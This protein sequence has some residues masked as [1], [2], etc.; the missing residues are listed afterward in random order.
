MLFMVSVLVF[1]SLTNTVFCVSKYWSFSTRLITL[2]DENNPI[3]VK[4][5]D[6]ERSL[7]F[8]QKPISTET[9]SNLQ[10][11]VVTTLQKL[12]QKSITL[13]CLY[14]VTKVNTI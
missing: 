14:N 10:F 6:M 5:I 7:F 4:I 11:N 2:Q 3:L 1:F 8:N 13:Q 12:V 9:N